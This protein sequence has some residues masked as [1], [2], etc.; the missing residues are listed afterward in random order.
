[1]ACHLKMP[2][3]ILSLW[4]NTLIKVMEYKTRHIAIKDKRWKLF[5]K[6]HIQSGCALL[7]TIWKHYSAVVYSTIKPYS[8][9]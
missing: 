4:D 8:V 1:M 5:D 6:K 2:N 9:M 7:P 3:G